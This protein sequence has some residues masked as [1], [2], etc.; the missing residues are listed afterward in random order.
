MYFSDTAQACVQLVLRAC[1]SK[2][3]E[4]SEISHTGSE[5]I[6]PKENLQARKTQRNE[7]NFV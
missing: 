3:S 5:T 4:T 6:H 7:E 1:V 2:H